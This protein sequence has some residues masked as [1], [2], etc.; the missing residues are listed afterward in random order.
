MC[1]VGGFKKGALVNGLSFNQ[2]IPSSL[3]MDRRRKEEEEEAQ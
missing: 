1:A 3:P 2:G